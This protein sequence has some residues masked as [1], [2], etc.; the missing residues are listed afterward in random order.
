MKPQILVS[1]ARR[2]SQREDLAETIQL[3][4]NLRDSNIAQKYFRAL[5]IAASTDYIYRRERFYNFPNCIY[6][7]ARIVERLNKMIEVINNHKPGLIPEQAT[8]G[9]N[10]DRMNH[11]HTYFEKYRGAIKKPHE[12]YKNAPWEVKEAFDEFNLMIHRYEDA[13]Y[14]GRNAVQDSAKFYLTFGMSSRLIHYLTFG[15]RSKV[16]RYPLAKEDFAHFSF[17]QNFG[18]WI[19]NYCEVGK[20]LHDVWRDGDLEIGHEAVLPLQYYSADAMITLGHNI[21]QEQSDHK[22]N[23][24][25]NWWDQNQGRLSE[26]GFAKDNPRN[27]IGHLVVADIDL[28]QPLLRGK[29]QAEI[30]ELMSQYQWISKVEGRE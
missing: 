9:M 10:Q 15:L 22:K 13:G 16:I 17:E 11:L 8:C 21:T 26:L 27:S 20:P 4:W 1:F 7:E 19:I 28:D 2:S 24:F 25:Y 30:V 12:V 6:T 3:S 29:S 5:K 14:S 18:S 23:E